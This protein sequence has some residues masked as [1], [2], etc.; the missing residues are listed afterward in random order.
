IELAEKYG[1]T[2]AQISVAW[3]LGKPEVTA[4]I[5][6]VSKVSQ[7]EQLVAAADIELEDSDVQYL[8][9][10]YQPVENLLSIGMS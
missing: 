9:E 4:P 7:L 8:E 10:L 1:H 6:G 2:P 5:V 3:L